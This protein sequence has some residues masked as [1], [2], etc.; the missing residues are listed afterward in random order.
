[1]LENNPV[2]AQFLATELKVFMATNR[3]NNQKWTRLRVADY[4]TGS[5]DIDGRIS[6]TT[7]GRFL[8]LNHPQEPMESTLRMVA[9]FLILHD[10]I[11]QKQLDTF[12]EAITLRA[13]LSLAQFFA[14][15]ET[16]A[17]ENFLREL[18][19]QYICY[20][21]SAPFLYE[22]RLNLIYIKAVNLLLAHEKMCLYRIQGLEKVITATHNFASQSHLRT[23][24]LLQKFAAKT[25]FETQAAGQVLASADLIGVFLKPDSKGFASML[26][27]ATLNY[28]EDD[29]LLSLRG[30]RNTG[31]AAL[32]PGDLNLPTRINGEISERTA[33]R[34]LSE[35]V[36]FD[37]FS[38]AL[39][40]AGKTSTETV[41]YGD[42]DIRHFSNI[43]S[44]GGAV[45][46][47]WFI[48]K[49]NKM[50]DPDERLL[51]AAEHWSLKYF[52][53]ALADK[54]DPNVIMP[55]TTDTLAS[56]FAKDGNLEWAKALVASERYIPQRDAEGMWPSFHA[57]VKTRLYAG[58]PGNE[59][60]VE[61]FSE[62]HRILENAELTA[63]AKTAPKHTEP[64][65]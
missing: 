3:L 27:I 30:K 10:H 61:K 60:L 19:G 55:G 43:N 15:P 12:S 46:N 40:K 11:N 64:H 56:S 9:V 42:D 6:N 53:Q 32:A 1:M 47:T 18:A 37:R 31:W 34:I 5:D 16:N 35:N 7:L 63:L 4:I 33:T 22:S 38:P 62:L 13:G 29:Q 28:G 39:T 23:R 59:D 36:A 24:K 58:L 57:G 54:A 65:I 45:E 44:N 52:K 25:V 20:Q 51:F 21:A 14:I 50:S 17:H 2:V 49:Y 41:E 48:E 8:N 26:N